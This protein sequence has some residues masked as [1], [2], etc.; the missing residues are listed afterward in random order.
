MFCPKCGAESTLNAQCCH[1]CGDA[2]PCPG[3]G[4]SA[5]TPSDQQPVPPSQSQPQPEAVKSF[6]W[7][8]VLT[9]AAVG[10]VLALLLVHPP[11]NLRNPMNTIAYK[12]AGMFT[13]GFFG[14]IAGAIISFFKQRSLAFTASANAPAAGPLLRVTVDKRSVLVGAAIGA[15]AVGTL[16]AILTP[17]L[18]HD[19]E[20]SPASPISCQ[21]MKTPSL[22][23]FLE[24]ARPGN[25][26]RSD[27][28]LTDYWAQTYSRDREA[29]IKKCLGK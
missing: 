2:L 4:E 15:I 29:E 16:F 20:S 19:R 25:P 12:I 11:T 10:A 13:W 5:T 14:A 28:A 8:T 7:G 17:A 22:D 26:G 3:S 21:N 24:K 1:K 9:Y 23:E 18:V 27:A 6:R